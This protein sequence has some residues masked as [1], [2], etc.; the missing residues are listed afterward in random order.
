MRSMAQVGWPSLRV[1]IFGPLLFAVLVACGG[2]GENQADRPPW[3]LDS[4]VLPADAESVIAV[5]QGLPSDVGGLPRQPGVTLS[6][7]TLLAAGRAEVK[8]D[9]ER[10]LTAGIGVI[11]LNEIRSFAEDPEVTPVEFLGILAS[12]SE[13]EVEAEELDPDEALAYV[14]SR[15][16]GNGRT[17]YTIAWA[18]PEGDWFFSASAHTPDVRRAMVEAFI[19]SVRAASP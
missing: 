9:E 18:E 2:G 4:I 17:V 1:F 7:E 11:T 10:A 13:V 16:T 6:A 8:Y 5:L 3:G 14:V 19:Q 12:S 15:E